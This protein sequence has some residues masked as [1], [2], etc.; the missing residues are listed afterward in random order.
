MPNA[1]PFPFLIQLNVEV[2]MLVG[3][4]VGAKQSYP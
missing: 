2:G 1:E 4:L 3:K